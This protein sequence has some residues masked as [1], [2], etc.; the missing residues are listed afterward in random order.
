MHRIL[1]FSIH[2]CIFFVVVAPLALRLTCGLESL[3]IIQS[4]VLFCFS[5]PLRIKWLIFFQWTIHQKEK[6]IKKKNRMKRTQKYP[7]ILSNLSAMQAHLWIF[8]SPNTN[9]TIC[10]VFYFFSILKAI[11]ICY[12]FEKC[13]MQMYKPFFI[14]C[15]NCHS[16]E[17]CLLNT[18]HPRPVT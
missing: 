17:S 16:L 2:I 9:Y 4:S 13:L 14:T 18:M 11:N 10:I 5:F 8:L 3:L 6:K 7:S 12:G 1:S 15:T